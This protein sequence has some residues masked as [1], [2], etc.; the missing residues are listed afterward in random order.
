[1]LELVVS[2]RQDLVSCAAGM[3]RPGATRSWDRRWPRRASICLLPESRV[4]CRVGKAA[5]AVL[6]TASRCGLKVT[7]PMYDP[8][9]ARPGQRRRYCAPRRQRSS[10]STGPGSHGSEH[11]GLEALRSYAVKHAVNGRAG[12]RTRQHARKNRYDKYVD[13]DC[14]QLTSRRCETVALTKHLA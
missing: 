2:L 9:V 3:P 14:R 5:A 4:F 1:V 6:A 8:A 12:S 11:I 10:A 7:A 13:R